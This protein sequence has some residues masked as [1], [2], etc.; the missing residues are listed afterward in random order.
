MWEKYSQPDGR[1]EQDWVKSLI[2]P[3]LSELQLIFDYDDLS[4]KDRGDDKLIKSIDC[5]DDAYNENNIVSTKVPQGQVVFT[6]EPVHFE[7]E[8]KEMQKVEPLT[9]WNDQAETKSVTAKNNMSPSSNLKQTK[10]DVKRPDVDLKAAIRMV[11]RHYHKLFREVNPQ[12][13]RRRISKT[14]NW[15]IFKGVNKVLGEIFPKELCT[16]ELCKFVVGICKLKP[17]DKFKFKE[18]IEKQIRDYLN[19]AEAYSY[20]K[21]LGLL[22]SPLFRTLWR[23]MPE[24]SLPESFIL[25]LNT[26]DN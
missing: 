26:F 14:K 11:R 19:W 15:L 23:G 8:E 18:D 10:I 1:E 22:N 17:M 5:F 7:G 20:S 16:K 21:L 13:L 3:Q 24:G 2:T 6:Q 25:E 9:P 12:V 4:M